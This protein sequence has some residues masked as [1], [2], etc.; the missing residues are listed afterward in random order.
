MS[1]L[2]DVSHTT[3]RVNQLRLA[4]VVDLLPQPRDHHVHDV[5]AGVEMVVPGVFGD[6]RPR[7]DA[8]L[9]AHQ[10]LFF[11][12]AEDGIRDLTVTGVQTCA[13]PISWQERAITCRY[14]LGAILPE[15]SIGLLRRKASLNGSKTE[16]SAD[17]HWS[18]V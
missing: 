6:E 4:G 5:R 17:V 11:F 12:Q 10:V 1:R 16:P 2:H 18:K 7:H 14:H 15:W 8:P 9:V 13:L 3:H